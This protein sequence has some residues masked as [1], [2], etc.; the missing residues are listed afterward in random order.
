MDVR[1]VGL[2][3]LGTAPARR[4]TSPSQIV[5]RARTPIDSRRRDAAAVLSQRL[6]HAL[7]PKLRRLTCEAHEPARLRQDLDRGFLSVAT[8]L[9]DEAVPLSTEVT[10]RVLVLLDQ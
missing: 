1:C 9:A 3:L 10:K 2:R 7:D 5:L 8:S 6:P 4:L